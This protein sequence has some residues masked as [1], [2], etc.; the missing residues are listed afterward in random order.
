[1][2][3]H[4]SFK[5]LLFLFLWLSS[6]CGESDLGYLTFRLSWPSKE[7]QSTKAPERQNLSSIIS[8]QSASVN[9]MADYTSVAAI[10][11]SLWQGST[12]VKEIRYDYSLHE[13]ELNAA[14]G[15]YLF[16]IEGL[17]SSEGILF[18]AEQSSVKVT[19]GGTTDLGEITLA[20]I[21][22]ASGGWGEVAAGYFHSCGITPDGKLWCWGA[23]D[24]GQL[25]DGINGGDKNIP[26]RVTSDV[27]WKTVAGG[28]THTCGIK[29]DGTLWCWGKN[30]FGQLGIETQDESLSLPT[31]VTSESGWALISAGCAH[32]CGVKTDSTFW[33][34]GR[35]DSGQLGIGT[36]DSGQNLPAQVTGGSGWVSVSTGCLHTCGIKTDSTLWCWGNNYAG[37][38]GNNNWSSEKIPVSV[39]ANFSLVSGGSTHTCGILKDD[40]LAC[41]GENENGQLGDGSGDNQNTPTQIRTGFATVSAGSSHTCGTT[42]NGNLCC[43]GNNEYGQLGNGNWDNLDIPNCLNT[44][45]DWKILSG[46]SAHTCGI[47]N[48][49]TLWCW[50]RNDSGQLGNG[51][52]ENIPSPAQ[53]VN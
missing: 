46:G 15:T 30:D 39:N 33:C 12:R 43:W 35:N 29:T 6:G 24:L 25:G 20:Q 44:S 40:S 31:Q 10:R 5:L 27:N 47:K 23:D 19:R 38:L 51:T 50:G 18:R 49:G 14:S 42:T 37:Q 4:P 1:M 52:W 9:P 3:K 8:Q 22:H 32:T 28:G 16:R 17:N 53:V 45:P 7:H 2:I 36:T 26:T 11:A 48:D 21:E 34:W 41:W 13:A